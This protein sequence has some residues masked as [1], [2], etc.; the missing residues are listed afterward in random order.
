MTGLLKIMNANSEVELAQSNKEYDYFK[1]L[2]KVQKAADCQKEFTFDSDMIIDYYNLLQATKDLHSL[3]AYVFENIKQTDHVEN[4]PTDFKDA[5]HL[6][7][8]F[9]KQYL[10]EIIA[11]ATTLI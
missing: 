10:L 6:S 1:Q 5:L 8:Y 7:G 2:E 4:M 9:R 3:M 11:L